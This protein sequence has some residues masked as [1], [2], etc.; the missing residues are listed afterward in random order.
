MTV[1]FAVAL[2]K[3]K[4]QFLFSDLAMQA[5]PTDTQLAD[6]LKDKTDKFKLPGSIHFKQIYFNTDKRGP[7]VQSDAEQL[8]MRL[9]Q[10]A[11]SLDITQ[12]TLV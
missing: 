9:R 5:E 10:S 2:C 4:V 12:A 11:S 3:K 6:Y 8:L 1:L 7:Q